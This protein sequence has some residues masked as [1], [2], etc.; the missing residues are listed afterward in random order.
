MWPVASHS[1]CVAPI[2]PLVVLV[3]IA[4]VAGVDIAVV[5]RD[6]PAR[7]RVADNSARPRLMLARVC[8]AG[9]TGSACA[10][11]ARLGVVPGRLAPGGIVAVVR[12]AV[13][14]L[15]GHAAARHS[16]STRR[17]IAERPLAARREVAVVR[18]LNGPPVCLE[19]TAG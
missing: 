15:A 16:R 1:R 13:I 11:V 6:A 2:R 10:I 14:R 12:V 8:V 9:H 5:P 4:V 3:N 7:V 18:V 17:R 19:M